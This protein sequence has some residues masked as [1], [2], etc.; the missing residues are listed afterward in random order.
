MPYALHVVRQLVSPL[1]AA[2]DVLVAGVIAATTAARGIWQRHRKG[3]RRIAVSRLSPEWL[4][5]H[6]IAASKSPDES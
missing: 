3:P 1:P 5:A 2:G 4:R 6:A